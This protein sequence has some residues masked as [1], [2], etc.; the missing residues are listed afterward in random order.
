MSIIRLVR[1]ELEPCKEG[2][3][4]VNEFDIDLSL[5][6]ISVLNRTTK[7]GYTHPPYELFTGKQIDYVRDFRVSHRRESRKGFR[8]TRRLP[9]SEPW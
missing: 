1:R 5:G 3:I 4:P 9:E 2:F 7:D 8:V 6:T